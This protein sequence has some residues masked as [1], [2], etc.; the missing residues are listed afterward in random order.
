[1]L[2]L[3]SSRFSRRTRRELAAILEETRPDV[4]HAH[5]TRAAWFASRCFKDRPALGQLLY[6]EHLFS[7]AARRGPSKLPW[8][9]LERRLCRRADA[10]TTSCQANA[11]HALCAG[12]V[13]PAR[14]PLE[15]YGIDLQEVRAQV[16]QPISRTQLGIPAATFIIGT[17]GRLTAQK[18]L[19]YLL[20][21]AA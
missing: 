19:R 4:V 10:L 6:S 13:T 17:L 1:P 5:G 15:H 3:M 7:F 12:W 20:A 2:P 8:Y 18:G 21:A 11:R 9:L 16:A 14:L